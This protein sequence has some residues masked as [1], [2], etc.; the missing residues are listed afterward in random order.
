MQDD[1]YNIKNTASKMAAGRIKAIGNGPRFKVNQTVLY[2][3][4]VNGC[5]Y[6]ELSAMERL[7]ICLQEKLIAPEDMEAELHLCIVG[8]NNHISERLGRK[9]TKL[10]LDQYLELRGYH[11]KPKLAGPDLEGVRQNG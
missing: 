9:D 4:L 5:M 1:L 2:E 11:D 6:G 3:E 7:L 8:L 10:K